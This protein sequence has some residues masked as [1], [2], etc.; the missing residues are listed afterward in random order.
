M[1]GAFASA[2]RGARSGRC[3]LRSTV[4]GVGHR[5]ELCGLHRRGV[6]RRSAPGPCAICQGSYSS[7]CEGA[8]LKP[9]YR[10]YRVSSTM[11]FR[12]RLSVRR[13][14]AANTEHRAVVQELV[15]IG[16]GK[17]VQA[18]H[19]EGARSWSVAREADRRFQRT[20][21]SSRFFPAASCAVS[22][23][24]CLPRPLHVSPVRSFLYFAAT[25]R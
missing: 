11:T 9:R 23:R 8:Y 6:R 1:L 15:A 5:H 13:S 10:V 24:G 22:Q 25:R 4:L 19:E 3:V 17:P 20:R 14:I 16:G 12:S 18:L 21:K 7:R 2:M